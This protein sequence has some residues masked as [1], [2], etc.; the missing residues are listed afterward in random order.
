MFYKH[1]G[2]GLAPIHNENQLR[3]EADEIYRRVGD[4]VVVKYNYFIKNHKFI[5]GK[6]GHIIMDK[7]SS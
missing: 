1:N 2:Q 3:L 4:M 7:W 5:G 6:I